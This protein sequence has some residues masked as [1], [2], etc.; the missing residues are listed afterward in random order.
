MNR[1]GIVRAIRR[2]LKPYQLGQA[3]LFGSAI[4][5]SS[6]SS[7]V[8]L[9]VIARKRH[10]RAELGKAKREF[11]RATKRRLHVQV[12]YAHQIGTFASFFRRCGPRLR[13][14]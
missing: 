8:D 1:H 3:Y 7:D 5:K 13:C 11:Q 14:L 2:H 12:F 10:F 6:Q 4:H 9:I